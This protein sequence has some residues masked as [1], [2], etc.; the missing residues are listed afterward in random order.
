MTRKMLKS[1]WIRYG[2]I[3]ESEFV[4][5]GM[6]INA[7][8]TSLTSSSCLRWFIHDSARSSP[9]DRHCPSIP[10]PAIIAA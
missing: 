1:I 10:L 5:A 7:K 2:A 6:I 4:R 3:L 8:N 9:L